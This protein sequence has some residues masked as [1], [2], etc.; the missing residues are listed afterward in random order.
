MEILWGEIRN[1]FVEEL[2]NGTLEMN[3]DAWKTD[4]DNE[5]G[6][7][8]AKIIGKKIDGEIEIEVFYIDEQARKDAYAQ[9]VI[10]EGVSELTEMF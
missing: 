1:D 3:I 9:E 10:L 4:D 8:I 7:V 2:D 6:S 5:E